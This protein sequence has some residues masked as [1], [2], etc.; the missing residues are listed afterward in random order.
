MY[1]STQ[2]C[3][4]YRG[5][6]TVTWSQQKFG[7]K[8]VYG[9]SPRQ[10]RPLSRENSACLLPVA[11]MSRPSWSVLGSAIGLDFPVVMGT[12]VSRNTVSR[13]GPPGAGP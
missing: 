6:A 7:P 8:M 3:R 1:C 13:R 10:V 9:S 4:W 2:S 12:V 5:S 11:K